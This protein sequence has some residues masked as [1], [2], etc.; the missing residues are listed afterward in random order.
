MTTAA[1]LFEKLAENLGRPFSSVEAYGLALRKMGWWQP[2]KRGRSANPLTIED[3]AKLLLS[4][5]SNGPTDIP[6]FVTDYA[7][8]RLFE[9]RRREPWVQAVAAALDLDL[10]ASFL[11]FVV[12]FTREYASRDITKIIF[13]SP[14]PEGF[15]GSDEEFV[16]K[17]PEIEVRIKGPMP[18]ASISFLLS[19]EMLEKIT[20]ELKD[21]DLLYGVKELIFWDALYVDLYQAIA[22]D[23]DELTESI[24]EAIREKQRKFS[25]GIGFERYFSAEKID[26]VADAYR[27]EN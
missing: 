2:T 8:L 6:N 18:T 12:A 15:H 16:F 21:H 4:L 26:A 23:D 24:G 27:L 13:Y 17:G 22:A 5:L 11:D 1:R 14:D 3:G 7:G 10:D 19:H 9:A 25:K 20:P